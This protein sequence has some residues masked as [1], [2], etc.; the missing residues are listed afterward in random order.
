MKIA[1]TIMK[2]ILEFLS[3]LQSERKSVERHLQTER[4]RMEKMTQR[5]QDANRQDLEVKKLVAQLEAAKVRQNI[6]FLFIINF[7]NI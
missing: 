2:V 3:C 4:E 7:F 6:L 1:D 5:V